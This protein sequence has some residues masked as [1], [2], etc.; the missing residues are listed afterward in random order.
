MVISD[1]R[2][3]KNTP[4]NSFRKL[5][6]VECTILEPEV[7][8]SN[9]SKSRVELRPKLTNRVDEEKQDEDEDNTPFKENPE[10]PFDYL[11]LYSPQKRNSK[12]F[13]PLFMTKL[14]LFSAGCGLA[15]DYSFYLFIVLL[16][17]EFIFM[18]SFLCMR[19]FISCFTN[20]RI[21]MM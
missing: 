6:L 19:P 15:H 14:V 20:F 2:S 3:E 12:Y 4:S 7:F 17:V 16:T 5:N 21:I 10:L 18:I 9:E 11:S 1:E 13:L 8:R